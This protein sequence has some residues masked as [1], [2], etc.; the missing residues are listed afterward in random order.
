MVNPCA[1]FKPVK[2]ERERAHRRPATYTQGRLDK[3]FVACSAFEKTVYGTLLLTGLREQELCNL[4]WKDVDLKKETLRVTGEGKE[5]F[6][7]KDCEERVIPIPPDLVALLKKLS[8]K[9]DWVFP[10]ALAQTA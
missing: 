9:S 8:R 4:T 3:L 10:T 7:P 6:S 5:G 1:R 2:D